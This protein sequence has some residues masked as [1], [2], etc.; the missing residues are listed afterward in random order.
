M[1]LGASS[2]RAAHVAHYGRAG[3]VDCL[4]VDDTDTAIIV[5]VAMRVKPLII[6]DRTETL[7]RSTDDGFGAVAQARALLVSHWAVNSDAAV[8]LPGPIAGT[9]DGVAGFGM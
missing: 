6:G 3:G 2:R 5:R 8:K 1:V 4:D 9:E 7:A